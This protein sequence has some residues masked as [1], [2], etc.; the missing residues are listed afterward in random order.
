MVKL[1]RIYT[2][3]G[4]RGRTMLGDGAT[5][6]KG[7]PRVEAYGCV[8]EANSAIGVAISSLVD[9]DA[10][11]TAVADLLEGVQNDLFDVGADLSRPLADDEAEGA[12]LR[13][14]PT[15]TLRI[16]EAIDGYLS[17]LAP[18]DS[19]V[20]PGGTVASALLHAARA[21]VRR[22]ERRVAALLEIEPDTTNRECLVYLN[23]LSDL[24]FVLARVCND[25]GRLD[26]KWVPGGTR[27]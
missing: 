20:L 7:D 22:A 9:G 1:N 24:L 18:L 6:S 4:D 12:A 19:F 2:K 25:F 11:D 8:D 13:V 5:V 26:V 16:E 21:S 3:V 10:V 14:V 23:R 17:D 27:E 15:M